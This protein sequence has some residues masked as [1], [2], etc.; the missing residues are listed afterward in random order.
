MKKDN[1]KFEF[2]RRFELEMVRYV[3]KDKEGGLIMKKIKGSQVVV[4]EDCL[5]GEGIFK[6]LKK[7]KKMGCK[8]MVKEVIKEL[9]E[10]KN[11]VEVVSKDDIG[12]MDK[13]MDEV[14]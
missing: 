2:E 14:Y 12:N 13:I 8:N 7:K 5:I 6:L 1:R 3:L 9:V 10:C 4:I 11:Q